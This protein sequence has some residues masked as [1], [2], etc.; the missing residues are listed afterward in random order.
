MSI[1]AKQTRDVNLMSDDP[2]RLLDVREAAALLRVKTKTLYAWV[3]RN[4]IPH[5]KIC[6]LVRFH[7]GELIEWAKGQQQS[8]S[9]TTPKR[10]TV[11][12]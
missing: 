3:S 10:L 8:A 12:E 1:P 11:V 5:R 6:S 7:R 2:E 4:K 9:N